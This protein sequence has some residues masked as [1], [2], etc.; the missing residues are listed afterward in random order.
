MTVANQLR[1]YGE[2][3]VCP[4]RNFLPVNASHQ[5]PFHVVISRKFSRYV[6][7]LKKILVAVLYL[8]CKAHRFT[9][10]S[11][12]F[13]FF[14]LEI[15]GLQSVNNTWISSIR[16]S[17]WEQGRLMR[18]LLLSRKFEKAMVIA[19]RGNLLRNRSLRGTKV[20]KPPS[21]SRRSS[22]IFAH[23]ENIHRH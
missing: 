2:I 9:T 5:H 17:S 7:F 14:F 4:C 8:R 3:D 23:R 13:F 6:L 18:K 21:P 22:R 19:R 15:E 1:C 12:R 10:A 11:Y 16:D 20:S